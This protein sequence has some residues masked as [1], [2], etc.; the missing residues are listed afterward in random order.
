MDAIVGAWRGT[1]VMSALGSGGN[2][3]DHGEEVGCVEE[4]E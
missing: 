4:V 3:G 2:K 1:G